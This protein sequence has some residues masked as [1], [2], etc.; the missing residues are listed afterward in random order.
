MPFAFGIVNTEIAFSYVLRSREFEKQDEHNEFG[1]L[2][3][4]WR[5]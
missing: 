4:S 1:A 2:L 5:Y 3:L